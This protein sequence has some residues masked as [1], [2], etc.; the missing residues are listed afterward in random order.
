MEVF[1]G[2]DVAKES[3]EVFVR[4]DNIRRSFSNDEQGR[5]SLACLL[6]KTGSSLVVLAHLPQLKISWYM[7]SDSY[8]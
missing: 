1:A 6:G 5:T 3:L 8:E 2:I 7:I 4:P